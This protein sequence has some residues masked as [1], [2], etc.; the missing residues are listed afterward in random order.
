MPYDQAPAEHE[1]DSVPVPKEMLLDT[2]AIVPGGE[3][4][5]RY[6]DWVTDAQF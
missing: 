2:E 5:K 4:G 3:V 6:Q 1:A